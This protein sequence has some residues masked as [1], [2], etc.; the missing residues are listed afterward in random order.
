MSLSYFSVDDI[1]I[2]ANKVNNLSAVRLIIL[3]R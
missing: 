2:H 1:S 3:L